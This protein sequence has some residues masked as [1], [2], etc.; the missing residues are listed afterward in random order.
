MPSQNYRYYCLDGTGRLHDAE[1]F[2]AES[3]ADAIAQVVAKH[4]RDRCEI[5][6]DHRL[7]AQLS[8]ALLRA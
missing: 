5:W 6:Q 3:D 1:W 4:P 7:V 2:C 8:P